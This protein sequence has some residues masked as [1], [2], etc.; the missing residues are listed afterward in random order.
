MLEE[1]VA[2]VSTNYIARQAGIPVGS[3]YQYFPDKVAILADII[4]SSFDDLQQ[5]FQEFTDMDFSALSWQD[6]CELY[7]SKIGVALQRQVM[8]TELDRAIQLH[9]ELAKLERAHEEVFA[10][11]MAN[12]LKRLGS[13]WSK[14]RL[15]ML[16]HFVYALTRA[17][18]GFQFRHNPKASDVET[19]GSNAFISIIGEC[20]D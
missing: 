2:R 7:S 10:R 11:Q 15:K 20:M 13:R 16:A 19:W 6:Y 17:K 4:Q 8:L 12:D 5:V 1:G 14:P 18:W 3:V 9:P